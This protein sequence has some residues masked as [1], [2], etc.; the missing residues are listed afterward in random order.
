MNENIDSVVV[1]VKINNCIIHND[2][3]C[4]VWEVIP[5]TDVIDEVISLF[6]KSACSNNLKYQLKRYDDSI[7]INFQSGDICDDFD[8]A[9]DV[10][11]M[12]LEYFLISK[13]L[14]SSA[15]ITYNNDDSIVIDKRLESMSHK[16]R[17]KWEAIFIDQSLYSYKNIG[18][19]SNFSNKIIPL[20]FMSMYYIT[21]ES[22]FCL[23]KTFFKLCY[24][25][26]TDISYEDAIKTAMV[27]YNKNPEEL[28]FKYN[29]DTNNMN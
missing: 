6:N 28:I 9:I 19:D 25:I 2:K 3:N 4:I 14:L 16:T 27:K 24:K 23:Q 26:E 11:K 20:S 1:L 21:L 18:K 10:S 22:L 17:N 29:S 13:Q 7:I 12:L 15:F 8:F 5:I